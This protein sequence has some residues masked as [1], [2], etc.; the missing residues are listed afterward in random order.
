[1]CASSF[2][3]FIFML[4]IK[5]PGQHILCFNLDVLCLAWNLELESQSRLRTL[6][7]QKHGF[8][9]YWQQ[10]NIQNVSAYLAQPF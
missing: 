5:G 1:M 7:M 4:I 2:S 9:I 6:L 3:N 10:P 8:K